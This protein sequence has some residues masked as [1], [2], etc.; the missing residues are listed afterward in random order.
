MIAPFVAWAQGAM[1]GVLL[2]LAI[3]GVFFWHPPEA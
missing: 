2:A 3:L 1:L